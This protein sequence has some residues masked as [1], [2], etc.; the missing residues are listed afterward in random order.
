MTDARPKECN[1]RSVLL[2][3]PNEASDQ[4]PHG[5]D[6]H[7]VVPPQAD[8]DEQLLSLWLHGRAEGTQAVYRAEAERMLRYIGKSLHRITLGDLQAFADHLVQ[9]GL[10]D[11]TRHRILAITKSLI[12]FSHRLGYLPFDVA[13]PLNLPPVRNRLSERIIDEAQV[14]RMI[15]LEAHPRNRALLLLLYAA[16]VRVSESASLTWRDCHQRDGGGQISVLGKGGKV[17]SIRLP[18]QV[19]QALQGLDNDA[20]LNAPV[21][22]SRNSGQLSRSQILRIVR[23]AANRACINKPVSPHWLRHAHASHSLDRSAPIH[24][25]QRTLGHASVATTGRYLHAR[26]SESSSDY[27]T[28]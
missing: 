21:F 2:H 14:Q 19:W 5:Q 7:A 10:A 26:P 25:V 16:G 8:T 17:R 6:E 20:D 23:R 3:S 1:K 18:G 12:A 13:R 27:L 9:K 24:L 11:T 28:L 4:V 22:T 15:A